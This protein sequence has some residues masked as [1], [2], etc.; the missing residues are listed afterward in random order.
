MHIHDLNATILHCLG[1]DHEK[2]TYRYQG[3]DFRLTD[4]HG[5]VIKDILA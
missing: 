1:Y 3:R 4:V 2:L 5:Q